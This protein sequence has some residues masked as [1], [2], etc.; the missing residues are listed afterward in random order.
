MKYLKLSVR[1]V[2]GMGGSSVKC[3]M[4]FFQ[5]FTSQGLF[6]AWILGPLLKGHVCHSLACM[7]IPVYTYG[8]IF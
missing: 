6:T 1:L 4:V 3:Y 2:G 5:V 8:L 7:N